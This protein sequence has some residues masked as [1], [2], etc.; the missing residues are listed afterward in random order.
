[1]GST[2]SLFCSCH[3]RLRELPSQRETAGGRP[4]VRRDGIYEWIA[5]GH[6]P[7]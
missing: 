4:R 7:A 2:R 1:M 5:P 3:F 6:D